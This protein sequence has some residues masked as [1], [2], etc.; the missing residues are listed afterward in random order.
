MANVKSLAEAEKDL[1]AA[2]T[3]YEE[4]ERKAS[5]ARS[6]ETDA[7]NGLNAA[8]KAFDAVLAE[9]RKSMPGAS[10][11]RATAGRSVA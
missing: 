3:A 2:K 6:A 10:D 1:L 4:A 7:L 5:W 9:V 8:Q 11:W